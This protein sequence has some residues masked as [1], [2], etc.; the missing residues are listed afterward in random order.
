[1]RRSETAASRLIS[2]ADRV[3]LG[4]FLDACEARLTRERSELAKFRAR[5]E[6]AVAVASDE[7]PEDVTTMHA[8][9]RMR[10]LKSDRTFVCTVDLPPDRE[11]SSSMRSALSWPAV[12]LLGAR[13]GE[14]LQWRGRSDTRRVRLE[15]VLFQPEAMEREARAQ[16][17]RRRSSRARAASATRKRERTAGARWDHAHLNRNELIGKGA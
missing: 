15:K 16:A 1:M 14:E 17:R 7:M 2:I 11:V 12:A 8:Q 13:E 10:D 3:R 9:V 4:R 6:S 5:L